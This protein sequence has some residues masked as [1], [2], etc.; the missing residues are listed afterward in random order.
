LTRTAKALAALAVAARFLLIGALSVTHVTDTDLW[1][2]LAAGDQIRQTGAIPH[3]ETFSYTAIGRRWLDVHWL[4]QV[5]LSWLYARGGLEVLQI[6]RVGLIAGLFALL[7]ARA[8]RAAGSNAVVAVLLLTALAS[9]ERFLL[10]PEI[11]SFM[12]L[13]IVQAALDRVLRPGTSAA[14][15]RFILWLLLPALQIVWVNVQGLFILGPALI[16]LACLAALTPP[17]DADRAVDLLV[18]L[19][20]AG[21]AC[22]VNPYGAATLRVPFEEF[23]GHLGGRSLLSRTIAEFQPPYSGYATTPAIAAFTVLAVVTLAAL[24]LSG[25]RARVASDSQERAFAWLVTLAMLYL[26]LRA[27][28]NIALFAVAAAPIL[29]GAASGAGDRLGAF[30]ARLRR[31]PHSGAPA[32]SPA[33]TAAAGWT[34]PAASAA[35]AAAGAFL[36]VLVVTNVFFLHPPTERWWG[37]GAIPDYFPDEAAAFV[38]AASLPGQAFHPLGAGG[39]LIY[40]WQGRRTV[41]IDGRNDPYLDDVLERYLA[42]VADPVTFEE[43]AKR[44]Q[45]TAV[46]WPHQWAIEGRTLLSY[47][48][49]SPAWRLVHLDA[50]AAVYVRADP[51]V[52][53]PL[54]ADP[55]LDVPDRRDLYARLLRSVEAKPF[56]GPPIREVALA[57]YFNV[58]GDPAGAEFFYSRALLV[59]PRSA[60]LLHGYGLALERQGRTKQALEAQ[61]AA[62]LAVPGFAPSLVAAGTL[63]VDAGQVEEGERLLDEA[64]RAGDRSARLLLARAGRLERQN[65][66]KEAVDVYR[67]AVASAPGNPQLLRE[68]ALF[69]LRHDDPKV[70]LSFYERARALAPGDQRIERERDRVLEAIGGAQ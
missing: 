3:Q 35:L 33:G 12:L 27:R 6:V 30:A 15:R 24:A 57:E 17:A 22:L 60:P 23:F 37:F 19:A 40:A 14:R 28:R 53:I 5:I 68:V 63:L 62:L 16:G 70:A 25:R 59:L 21:A 43:V 7:Y 67:E 58:A 55:L 11:V 9:Q 44:Y 61:R 2:H 31:R 10:R 41:F 52:P 34:A 46:L 50:G 47:L 69:Y 18:G 51:N 13:A 64:Y 56:D 36:L 20:A 54:E 29:A 65:K 32:G 49:R 42:S 48:G 66:I 38:Q 39:F 4:F 1:W 26:A 8:R 45:I